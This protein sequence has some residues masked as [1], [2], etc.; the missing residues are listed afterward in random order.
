MAVLDH[1]RLARVAD[2]EP[3]ALLAVERPGAAA[4]LRHVELARRRVADDG[5]RDLPVLDERDV[6]AV[7]RDA[8]HEVPGA[9]DRV[10]EPVGARARSLAAAFLPDHRQTLDGASNG[11]LDRDVRRRHEVACALQ[12]DLARAL[13]TARDLEP[14]P[15]RLECDERLGPEAVAQAHAERLRGGPTRCNASPARAMGQVMPTDA[16]LLADGNRCVFRR[17]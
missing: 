3:A 1:D 7:E 2:R 6:H 9:A 12:R 13:A 4:T 16:A 11:V 8:G 15:D 17:G 5:D 14:A 10:D